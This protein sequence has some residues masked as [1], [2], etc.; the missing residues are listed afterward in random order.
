ETVQRNPRRHLLVEGDREV[1]A[2]RI[3]IAGYACV[4]RHGG[5]DA[6]DVLL[7]KAIAARQVK[8]LID[9]TAQMDKYPTLLAVFVG[10]FGDVD[11]HRSG[12][13]VGGNISLNLL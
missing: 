10:F 12:V 13:E 5:F 4:V 2:A 8:R 7:G 3:A 11:E 6:I 9:L 1:A